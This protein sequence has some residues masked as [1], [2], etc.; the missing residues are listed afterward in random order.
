MIPEGTRNQERLCWRGPEAIYWTGLDKRSYSRWVAGLPGS[1][2]SKILS[3]R[4]ERLGNKNGCLADFQQ[5][6]ARETDSRVPISQ[7]LNAWER[8]IYGH[9]PWRNSKLTLTLLASPSSNLPS[10]PT[11]WLTKWAVAIRDW[12]RGISNVIILYLATTSE[13]N[14]NRRLCVCRICSDLYSVKLCKNIVTVC[15]Y[16]L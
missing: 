12:L 8:K 5:Q 13:D 2:W 7:K 11:D 16:E 4:P 1:W 10:R 6:F 9:C 14:K 3:L 15:S